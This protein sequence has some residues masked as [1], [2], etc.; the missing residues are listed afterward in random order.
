MADGPVLRPTRFSCGLRRRQTDHS[1]AIVPRPST[2]MHNPSSSDQK[3]TVDLSPGEA[4][5]SKI[6][7]R[8]VN[9]LDFDSKANA[10][11]TGAGTS[12]LI[13]GYVITAAVARGGMGRVFA[14]RE[15]ALDREVAIKT[16]VPGADAERFETESR[17]TAR[18][19]HPGIP[20]VYAL[21][22]LADG[23]P[24][25]VMKL[26]RGRT[27]AELL[28]ERMSPRENLARWVKV[29]EQISQAVGFAHSQGII[30]RDL[31]PRNVMV[32]AFGEVQVMDWGLAKEIAAP[33]PGAPSGLVVRTGASPELTQ[34]GTVMGTP[35]Y[36]APEQARGEA[37]DARADVFALGSVLLA[38]L[39]GRPAFTQATMV[40]TIDKT[41]EG[42]VTEALTRLADCG[43]DAELI[44]VCRRC[45]AP[46]ADQRPKHA[47]EVA[48]AVGSYLAAVED[49]ARRAEVARAEQAVK[50]SE[51]RKRRRVQAA[52]GLVFTGLVVLG[53][54]VAWRL[55]HQRREMEA[56]RGR[57]EASVSTALKESE[58]RSQ[59]AWGQTNDPARMRIATDLVLAAV[60][61]AE[62][63]ANTGAPTEELLTELAVARQKAAELD[64]HTRLLV[65]ADQ[66]LSE[67]DVDNTGTPDGQ[68]TTRRLAAAMRDFGWDVHAAT[69]QELGEQI[70]HNRIRNKVLGLWLNW[71]YQSGGNPTEKRKVKEVVRQ[72]RTMAGGVLKRWQDALDSGRKA[73]FI[74]LADD[75]EIFTLGPELLLSICG[76]IG[77]AGYAD[78]E[79]SLLRAAADRYPQHIWTHYVLRDVCS[80]QQPPQLAESL[81]HAA[82]AATVRPDSALLQYTLG[83]A[84]VRAESYDSAIV[85]FARA[86]RTAP[87]HGLAHLY[88]G[89]C[90]Q[91]KGDL[92]AAVASLRESATLMPTNALAHHRLAAAL[93]ERNELDEAIQAFRDA[94]RLEPGNQN[95]KQDLQ[96]ALKKKTERDA[97]K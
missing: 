45:L 41:A 49:R 14:G 59:E 27:L 13:A 23:S 89:Y 79:L 86:T 48:A 75:A 33:S 12:P 92:K 66:A 61:R 50:T 36:M 88:L 70:A 15:I 67:H 17:I 71:E 81:R 30:H 63:F 25:L 35:G 53:G 32:G 84:L 11:E 82:A 85:A 96:L 18:L 3:P 69:P 87:K 68:R 21:G 44:A 54:I 4:E 26:I 57:T 34:A 51:E 6:D 77:V 22:A 62:G 72:A 76:D 37:V 39:T 52:L 9:T 5:A 47:G 55:D 93:F 78:R 95:Y 74:A 2:T 91:R 24:Y 56:L 42:D 16:L 28:D 90:L 20:P 40:Q 65:S 19:Q 38:I 43:A 73:D 60:N 58:G 94:V 97:R 1:G 29:F 8:C 83:L 80:R 31:K 64:R 46:A 7:P 10:D